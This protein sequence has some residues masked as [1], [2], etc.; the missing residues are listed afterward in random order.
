MPMIDVAFGI[1]Q[2]V[3]VRPIHSDD[4][5]VRR[6]YVS[7]ITV[8]ETGGIAYRVRHTDIDGNLSDAWFVE[9][10]LAAEE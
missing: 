5:A 3:T 8:D 9:G 1:T 2:P 7:A 10:R 6:G 4:R